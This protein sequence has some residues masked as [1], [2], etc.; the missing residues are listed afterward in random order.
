LVV[1][2]VD[3]GVVDHVSGD[4]EVR[5][6]GHESVLHGGRFDSWAYQRVV[7]GWLS[8]LLGIDSEN[9]RPFIC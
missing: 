6:V 1:E 2:L 3:V 4:E 7:R 9:S 5:E 8:G